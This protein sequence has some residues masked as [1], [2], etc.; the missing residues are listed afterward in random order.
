VLA[1][2]AAEEDADMNFLCVLTHPSPRRRT[3]TYFP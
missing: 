2:T 3:I 1:G